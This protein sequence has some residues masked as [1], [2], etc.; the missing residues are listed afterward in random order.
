MGGQWRNN[1]KAESPLSD[2]DDVTLG[3]PA[4]LSAIKSEKPQSAL[5]KKTRGFP[6]PPH[7]GVGFME[8]I[9]WNQ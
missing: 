2:L 5:R 9:V 4:V 8:K 3:S 6:C 1:K 7:G